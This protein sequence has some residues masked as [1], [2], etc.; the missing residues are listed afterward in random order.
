MS[1]KRPFQRQFQ[2]VTV[3]EESDSRLAWMF[4]SAPDG[5]ARPAR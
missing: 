1:H 2:D 5:V 4:E 3:E